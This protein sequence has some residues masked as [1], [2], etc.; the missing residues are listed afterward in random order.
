MCIVSSVGDEYQRTWPYRHPEV[1][2]TTDPNKTYHLTYP[3]VDK[4]SKKEFDELK[5][6]VEAL[7]ELLK[8]A[9]IYDEATGQPDCEVDEKVDFIKKLGE[10]LGV[11]MSEVFGNK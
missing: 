10:L 8:A 7:K 3:D 1:P 2:W 11:D 9:K 5:K 6:E 4:V